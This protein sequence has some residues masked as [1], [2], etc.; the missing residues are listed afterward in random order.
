M[1]DRLRNLAVKSSGSA[2]L[3]T[4]I[5]RIETLTAIFANTVIAIILMATVFIILSEFGINIA[6]LLAGAGIIGIAVGF[7]AQ[8]LVKDLFAGMF[9]LLENQFGL[10]DIIQVG[11]ATGQVE[12][13]TLRTVSLRD[14]DGRLHIIPNSEAGRVIV[15]T[16]GWSC[17]NLNLEVAYNTNLDA[18][19]EAIEITSQ[20]FYAAHPDLLMEAPRNLGVDVFSD[21]GMVLKV[22]AKTYPQKQWESAR[23]Y[24]KAIKEAFDKAG[25]VMSTIFPPVHAS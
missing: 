13:M 4:D 22:L 24:R 15:Y 3:S 1:I 12:Q 14:Q 11:G 6:P 8:S 10:G 21:K 25:I 19:F 16:H 2:L 18:A 20:K 7:G 23:L 9:I 5:K 17:M